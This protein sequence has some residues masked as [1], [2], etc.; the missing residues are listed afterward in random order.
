MHVQRISSL[1]QVAPNEW[2]ALAVD[3]PWASH[4]WLLTMEQSALPQRPRVY[5]L[6]RDS[7]GLA[8]V[9]AAEIQEPDEWARSLDSFLFGRA[10]SIGRFLGFRT[11]PAAVVQAWLVGPNF[12]SQKRRELAE[13]LLET[14][15][16]LALQDRWSLAF[17]R[18]IEGDFGAASI[19]RR[20]GYL[21]T[22]EL[23]LTRLNIA[24]DWKSFADYRSAL[25]RTHP[26]AE[27]S[28]R[29]EVNLAARYKLRIEQ[30]NASSSRS[31]EFHNLL[32]RHF[33]RLNGESFPY[34]PD[35]IERLEANLGDQALL[36]AGWI[37]DELA[38][39]S[40]GSRAGDTVHMVFV[41]VDHEVGR[42]AAT[43][44][45][46]C[47]NWPIEHWI[48]TGVRE[49]DSGTLLYQVKRQRGF[50][51]VPASL[52]L[53]GRDGFHQ[54]ILGPLARAHSIRMRSKFGPNA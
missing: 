16:Q 5:L 17:R 54:R 50:H 49:A 40:I 2:D 52:F 19:L 41:G 11:A 23:P 39:L 34:R 48:E 46:L 45:N 36:L 18:V 22:H 25:R 28:I 9:L 37:G 51:I 13:S 4:G 30:F 7:G 47:Y 32:D 44:F 27:S 43:L 10:A 3:K 8:A 12:C 24:A 6:G 42:R 21:Q 15:E 1:R 20:R 29:R 38:G 53:R 35:L 31:D 33:R 14:L 26:G